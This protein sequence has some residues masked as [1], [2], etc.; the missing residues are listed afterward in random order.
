MLP[1]DL[2]NLQ[3]PKLGLAAWRGRLIFRG[4]FLLLILATLALAL[5]VLKE[6]KQR[7]HQ[8]YL[9]GFH[10]TQAEIVARLRHPAGQLALLNPERGGTPPVPLRPLLLPYAAIDFDDQNK[11][12]Q[13]AEMAGCLIQ[14]PQR[15]A[16]CAGI[17]NNPYAGGYIYLVG[18]FFAGDLVGRAPGEL[19]LAG[20]H[21]ARVTL[22][23]RGE[24]TQWIAPFEAM[25]DAEGASVRGRLTG[26]LVSGDTLPA[27]ARPVRDFRGW[28]WQSRQCE[29]SSAACQKPS[30]FSIRLPVEPFREAL[31]QKPRPV[32][33]PRDLDEIEVR[34]EV[35][36]PNIQE[37]VFDSNDKSAKA[38]FALDELRQ[39]L[40]PGETLQIR[41]TAAG[42]G[43]DIITLKGRGDPSA[44]TSPLISKL[45][46]RLPVE[47][48]DRP[49]QVSE[50]LY[51]ST[52]SYEVTLTGDVRGLDRN[53]SAVATRMSWYVAAMLG[54]I[55]LAWLL[56]EISFI[57][58]V[59]ILT[60]RAATV[61]YNVQ[62]DKIEQ[63][64]THLD[65]SDL[66]GSDEL[67]I[68]ASSLSDLLQR[69]KDDVRREHIRAQQERDMWHAVGH[70][71]MSPLQSLMVLH[72]TAEDASHR[73][74]QRMQQA[75]RVLYGS[76]SP[77]EA[78]EAATLKLEYLD[79]NAFLTNVAGNAHFA[80][81]TD[82][83][84]TPLPEAVMVRAEAFSLEDVVTHILRNA[85]RH[86]LAG[87]PITITLSAADATARVSI[88]NQGAPIAPALI[89][90]IFE[91]GVSDTAAGENGEHRGQGLFVAKT[92]MAK[93][94]GTISAE[95]VDNGVNFVLALQRVTA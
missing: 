64:I 31:F 40:Q 13:A 52:G 23:M 92:Y 54:A 88:H 10:K 27:S 19:A 51:A 20:V 59:A 11:A 73:Y 90:K 53:L 91:Y 65:L 46:Q 72:P 87:T 79:L 35:F 69:V 93:M 38:P 48:Y 76:A 36:A 17:G 12:Q 56:I 14:Y 57:R 39:I 37:A 6:E 77:S 63:R 3:I 74:I 9:Q 44:V 81:L 41:K 66:R 15:G 45:I 16:V 75:V 4:A 55:A 25:A 70:E 82:V 84:F 61:A 21:R 78:L 60:K 94:S 8:S 2:T 30:F 50:T 24:T 34:L 1:L 85:E 47:G 22:T 29:E 89:D 95:N 62:D 58:R 86:R 7:S 80:G 42:G 28:L 33:P 68:L 71:I 67:G 49:L 32:W 26:F 43:H 83:R 5:V 18:N